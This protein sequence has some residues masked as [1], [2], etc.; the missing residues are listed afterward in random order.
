MDKDR[1]RVNLG[2]GRTKLEGYLNVDSDPLV[3]PDKV[4]D[5]NKL[6]WDFK[7]SSID[8]ILC[9]NVLEHLHITLNWFF[10]EASRILKPNGML[11]LITPNNFRLSNRIKFL[12]GEFG[13]AQG[14]HIH[15]TFLL[16]PSVIKELARQNNFD[17]MNWKPSNL[18]DAEIN[19][20][21]RKRP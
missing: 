15:H 13:Q 12:R 21:L 18:F 2:C 5:A 17:V 10:W 3:E 8:E 9:D 4:F 16:K 7:D 20:R 19:V 11:V 14:W 1:V 6:H